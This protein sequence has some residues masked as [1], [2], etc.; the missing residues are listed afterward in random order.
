[1]RYL[2]AGRSAVSGTP[3]NRNKM[4][5]SIRNGGTFYLSESTTQTNNDAF[6][7]D[8]N[9][10]EI[11]DLKGGGY[12]NWINGIA[13]KSNVVDSVA[14]SGLTWTGNVCTIGAIQNS[15]ISG[16]IGATISHIV[17]CNP[18]ITTLQRQEI[19][20]WG[21]HDCGQSHKIPFNN[22]FR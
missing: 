19:L 8:F 18:N 1:M 16:Y 2:I 4:I 21:L 12:S 7:T 11:R 17:I 3:S 9:A 15:T 20:A 14:R 5:A 13:Q 10:V 22:P 6:A